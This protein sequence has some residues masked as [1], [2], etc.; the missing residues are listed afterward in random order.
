MSE[1]PCKYVCFLAA[2]YIFE[3]HFAWLGFHLLLLFFKEYLLVQLF[4]IAIVYSLCTLLSLSLTLSLL[5]LFPLPLSLFLSVTDC[6]SSIHKMQFDY[7]NFWLCLSSPSSPFLPSPLPFVC[8]LCFISQRTC[9][10]LAWQSVCHVC[11]GCLSLIFQ[12]FLGK[13]AFK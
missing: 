9:I 3:S 1:I 5:S 12:C 2:V 11:L 8:L 7:G 13:R 6:N 10:I 4:C